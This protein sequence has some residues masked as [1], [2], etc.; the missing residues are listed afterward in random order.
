M[1]IDTGHVS[2]CAHTSCEKRA[3]VT[4]GKNRPQRFSVTILKPLRH[5]D[6]GPY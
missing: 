1:Q 3:A 4:T 6:C 2:I 5:L